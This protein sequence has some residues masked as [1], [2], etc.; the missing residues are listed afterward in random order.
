[1]EYDSPRTHESVW[2]QFDAS[3][4]TLTLRFDDVSDLVD[5]DAVETTLGFLYDKPPTLTTDAAPR[6]LA[7]DLVVEVVDDDLAVG[8]VDGLA[9]ALALGPAQGRLALVRDR[10]GAVRGGRR[11]R[12]AAARASRAGAASCRARRAL[13]EHGA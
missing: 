12:R 6:V 8:R 11:A 4:P 1:M 9:D 5:V 10:A 2:A 3:S 7:A 13:V